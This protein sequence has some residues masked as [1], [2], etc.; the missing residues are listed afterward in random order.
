[1]RLN[2]TIPD[3]LYDIY[4]ARAE[5]VQGRSGKTV[6]AE[7]LMQRQLDTFKRVHPADRVIVITSK[8][9][10]RLEA[11]LSGG[12]LR[13]SSDLAEKVQNLADIQIGQVR[14]DFSPSQLMELK[15][16]AGR[17]N[18]STQEVIKSTVT[19]MG[20]QFFDYMTDGG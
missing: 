11:I 3:E 14:V 16:Y 20:Y 1:V 7:E 19:Q 9:R 18:R 4:S 15:K 10:D 12:T 5:E 8:D 6:S 2:L 13:D 17:N